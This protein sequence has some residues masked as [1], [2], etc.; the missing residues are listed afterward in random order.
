MY[1]PFLRSNFI[2]HKRTFLLLPKKSSQSL[3]CWKYLIWASFLEATQVRITLDWSS[4]VSQNFLRDKNLFLASTYLLSI[5]V[6]M[7]AS[8]QDFLTRRELLGVKDRLVITVSTLYYQVYNYKF[9]WT[10][11][12]TIIYNI[13]LSYDVMDLSLCLWTWGGRYSECKC[14]WIVIFN[15]LGHPHSRPDWT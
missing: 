10:T 11:Q 13:L 7:S 9:G 8:G 2:V 14:W 1:H 12:L 5:I 4:K 3:V 6:K 15:R